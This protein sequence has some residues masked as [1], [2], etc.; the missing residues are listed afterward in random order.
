MLPLKIKDALERGQYLQMFSKLRM[1]YN[2]RDSI[3]KRRQCQTK[4]LLGVFVMPLCLIVL[5]LGSRSLDIDGESFEISS[6]EA[7]C[8]D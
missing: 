4:L 5:Y 8:V 2:R 6:T 7:G 3:H 1:L